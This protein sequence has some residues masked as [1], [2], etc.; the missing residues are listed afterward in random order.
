MIALI[1]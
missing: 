1:Y